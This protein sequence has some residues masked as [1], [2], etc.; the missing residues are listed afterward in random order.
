MRPSKAT[1]QYN[2]EHVPTYSPS[3][4]NKNVSE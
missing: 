2:S 3:E 1:K 4:K